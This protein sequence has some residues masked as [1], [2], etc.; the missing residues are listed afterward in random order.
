MKLIDAYPFLQEN[1][2]RPLVDL[3]TEYQNHFPEYLPFD[4]KINKGGVG[5]FLEKLIGLKNTSSLT[6]FSDGELKTNKSDISGKPLETMFISQISSSFDELIND[7]L[8]FKNS[9]IYQKIRNM[10]YVPICKVG[11]NPDNWFI[12]SAYHICLDHN[13]MVY[14]QLENDFLTIR[15]L[16]NQHI[17]KLDDGFIHTS[18]G[19][20]IQIRSKDSKRSDGTY[21]PIFSTTY[22]RYVSN[23]NHAFYFKKEFMKAIQAG[24]WVVH[25]IV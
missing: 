21:N 11:D 24:T 16:L 3:K 10:L 5:Q 15:K 8:A 18:N 7:D 1:Q 13:P 6:D 4:M 12:H 19:E 2:G 22:N 9:W 20:F 23:K 14:Q 17:R 25:K